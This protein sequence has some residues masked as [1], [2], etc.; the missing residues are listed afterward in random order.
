[1]GSKNDR[2]GEKNINNFG[3]EMIITEYR[4]WN[5]I[6][7]YFPQYDWGA[8]NRAY[9]DFK[10]GNIK[11]PYEPNVY[12][13]GYIGEGEYKSKEN[14]KS[15]KVYSTWRSMLQRCYDSEYHGKHSTYIGCS[16]IEEWLNFQNFA[17]WFEENYYEV[18]NEIMN[19]DKDILIKYNKIY[20]PETCIYVPQ[21]INKLFVKRDSKRGNN[22]IGVSDCE[23]GKYIVQCWLIN[24]ETGK[25]KQ[26]YLGCYET[27][28]K[29]FEVYKYYK[30]KNIKMVADYFKKY[31][32]ERLYDSLYKYEVEITD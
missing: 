14:G 30:E 22:P 13:V 17:K 18:P 3:S 20:S 8:R 23:N 5:D 6:D 10:K 2:T 32:P 19:L 28:E 29:G 16:V 7:V 21:T 27:Q 25:S 24:P 11:C 15:T 31:T 12:G 1:M 9:C 4:K 26:E